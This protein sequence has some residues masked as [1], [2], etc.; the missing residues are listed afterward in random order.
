MLLHKRERPSWLPQGRI[1]EQIASSEI[2]FTD[3]ALCSMEALNVNETEVK[4]LI[5]KKG[6][7][8]FSKSD[9]KRKPC[10]VYYIKGKEEK[11]IFVKV[12]MCD[13]ISTVMWVSTENA[14]QQ[15]K[16]CY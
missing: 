9:T 14:Q 5:S 16:H 3:K 8:F 11:E 10:P 4:S 12:E 6:S 13:S 15:N 7:V 1:L 2:R